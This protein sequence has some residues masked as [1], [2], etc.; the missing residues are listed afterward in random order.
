MGVAL[1]DTPASASAFASEIVDG[2]PSLDLE[3]TKS[4]YNVTKNKKPARAPRSGGKKKSAKSVPTPSESELSELS[5]EGTEQ[6]VDMSDLT[7]AE[8]IAAPVA[9]GKRSA[10]TR[11]T[12]GR[13]VKRKAVN[14]AE[15]D[16]D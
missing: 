4:V 6:D 12:N 7:D 3:K 15:G 8:E 10:P 11:A 13:S 14:Y 16:E 5:D 1:T 2:N 9:K